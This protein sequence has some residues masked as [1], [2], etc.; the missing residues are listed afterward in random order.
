MKRA[1]ISVHPDFIGD[2]CKSTLN[3]DKL[4]IDSELPKDAKFIAANFNFDEG[5]FHVL[6]DHDSFE[7]I[8]EGYKYPRLNSPKITRHIQKELKE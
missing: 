6:F 2:M 5:H 8:Q 1:F 3:G 7:D 4:S